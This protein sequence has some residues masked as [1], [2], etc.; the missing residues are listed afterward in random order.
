MSDIRL[1]TLRKFRNRNGY[2]RL[3]HSQPQQ[4]DTTTATPSAPA[5]GLR[6]DSSPMRA[7]LNSA[8]SARRNYERGRR[9][10]Q[11]GEGEPEEEATLLGEGERDSGFHNDEDDG[12]VVAERASDT[13]SQVRSDESSAIP[14]AFDV[15]GLLRQRSVLQ[16]GSK[17][18]SRTVPL[19]PPGTC[20]LR[21]FL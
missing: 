16:K 11:Y 15:S 10:N 18:K 9:R 2:E 20:A 17:G 5:P 7:P 13:N 21:T 8:S 12:P 3:D 4:Q 19:R 6:L 1:H 14:I